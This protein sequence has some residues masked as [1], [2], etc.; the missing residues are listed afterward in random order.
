MPRLEQALERHDLGFLKIVASAWGIELSAPDAVAARPLLAE[1]MLNRLLVEEVTSSLPA[2]AQ[3][4]LRTLVQ[5]EG[6]M[7][8]GQF[9][10]R[11]GDV[12]PMGAA[13][14]DRERPDLKPA[15]PAE[16]LWY[17]ALISRAFFNL[18][19]EPSEYAY[20][21]DDLLNLLPRMRSDAPQPFGR[22]AS[23]NECA[24]VIP[25]NDL[26]VDH[27]CSLLAALRAGVA[28]PDEEVNRWGIPVEVVKQFL[29]AG[30]LLDAYDTPQPEPTRFFLEA[31]R[32]HALAF[33]FR[34]W[35]ASE[36]F[37][38]LRLLPGLSFEGDWSNDPVVARQSVMNFVSLAPQ[39]TWWS[40]SAFLSA[41][42]DRQPDFQRPAG[43]YDSWYIRS[44]QTG[45]FLRGFGSWDEVDGALVRFLVT[46]PLH[47]LGILD[48][49]APEPG[50]PVTAFRF[51][52][53]SQSLWH[54]EP[55]EGFPAEDAQLT[56]SARGILRIPPLFPRAARYQIARFCQWEGEP[57]Q[58]F[59]YRY[60]FSPAALERARKQGLR[61]AQ[62]AALLKKY[63]QGSLPPNLLQALDRWENAGTQAK[64]EKVTL[65]Q[66]ANSSILEALRRTSAG[67]YIGA[68]INSTTAP[69][70]AGKEEQ[71]LEALAEIGYLAD[72]TD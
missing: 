22:P 58:N 7:L 34:A 23:P 6:R 63:N 55:P 37:N 72:D 61:T 4:A 69:V 32:A 3:E 29:I 14:R 1:A 24:S 62:L 35:L 40:L 13:R 47:W 66:V 11:F 16:S 9:T 2:A 33:L 12:R 65:L 57:N 17:R 53:W 28:L 8:W 59:R 15:S 60:R 5:N 45:A 20:I 26:L 43:D 48:L 30:H 71:V 39:D 49:A 51:S 67:R 38:E 50:A 27:T 21:P 64:L 52:P 44:L 31:P 46:G 19:P 56:A 10:R 18:P 41:I 54:G 36:T 25:A 68:A 70:Q 42:H